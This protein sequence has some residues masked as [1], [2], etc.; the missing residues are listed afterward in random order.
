MLDKMLLHCRSRFLKI[1]N[2]YFIVN[3]KFVL[4]VKD[5]VCEYHIQDLWHPLRKFFN[6]LSLFLPLLKGK[7]ETT[8]RGAY[9]YIVIVL[10]QCCSRRFLVRFI[11][12]RK[13]VIPFIFLYFWNPTVFELALF[14]VKDNP[15]SFYVIFCQV[16]LFQRMFNRSCSFCKIH[17]FYHHRKLKIFCFR[18]SDGLHT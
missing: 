10:F 16:T 13:G 15:L 4:A 12:E 9:F 3:G 17:R 7:R 11:C 6:I 5:D 14:V 8:T 18:L 1:D 2:E